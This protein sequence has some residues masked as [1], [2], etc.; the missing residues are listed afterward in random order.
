MKEY[1]E[2]YIKDEKP[3]TKKSQREKEDKN[4]S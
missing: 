1:E 2:L 4:C 3:L